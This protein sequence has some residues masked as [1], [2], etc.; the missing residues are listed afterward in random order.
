MTVGDFSDGDLIWRRQPDDED[1][2]ILQGNGNRSRNSSTL[3]W[4]SAICLAIASGALGGS[5]SPALAT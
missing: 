4:R 2:T 3:R 5:N 1:V